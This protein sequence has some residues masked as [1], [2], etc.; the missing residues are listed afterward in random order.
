MNVVMIS[1][2]KLPIKDRNKLLTNPS[3][4]SEDSYTLEA[5]PR[6]PS[7][8]ARAFIL[9]HDRNRAICIESEIARSKL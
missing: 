7:L 2:P 4:R 9:S 8:P 3:I 6:G 1:P 5:I